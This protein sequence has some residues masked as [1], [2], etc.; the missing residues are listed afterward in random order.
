MMAGCPC[1]LMAHPTLDGAPVL[2]VD[3]I[4]HRSRP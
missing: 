2:S 1:A 3:A 4:I